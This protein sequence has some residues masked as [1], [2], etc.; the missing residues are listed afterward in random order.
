M[1]RQLAELTKQHA[2]TAVTELIAIARTDQDWA[3]EDLA[4]LRK[5][6]SLTVGRIETDILGLVYGQ[7]PDLDDLTEGDLNPPPAAA[8]S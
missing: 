4:R 3:A 6:I 7:Y 8:A 5:A 2:L 1:N